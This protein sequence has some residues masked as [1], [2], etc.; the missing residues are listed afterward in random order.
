MQNHKQG[1]R[2]I[3]YVLERKLSRNNEGTYLGRVF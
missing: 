3:K 2:L 1:K